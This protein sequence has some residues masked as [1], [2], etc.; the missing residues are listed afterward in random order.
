VSVKAIE[1]HLSNVYRKLEIRSR[2][3]LA[4]SIGAPA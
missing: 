2:K 1:W 4:P 3:A